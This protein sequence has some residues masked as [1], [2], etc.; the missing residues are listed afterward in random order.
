MNREVWYYT[1]EGELVHHG[2]KGQKWGEKNGPPYPLKSSQ[3]SSSEKAVKARTDAGLGATVALTVMTVAYIAAV[4]KAAKST[5]SKTEAEFRKN[6][7]EYHEKLKKSRSIKSFDDA[8]KLEQK[9][10]PEESMKLTNPDYPLSGTTANCTFCT[11]AM[12]L[13][14]MGYKVKARKSDNL[15]MM[16][17]DLFEAAFGA[18]EHQTSK[19]K[20]IDELSAQGDG[21]YGNL[22]VSSVFGGGHSIFWKNVNGKTRIYD[23]QNGE[24]YTKT[25]DKFDEFMS[26]VADDESVCYQRLDNCKPTEYALALVEKSKR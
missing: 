18:K 24:E 16:T 14:E 5:A 23:G 10:P 21:S 19:T 6:R 9:M 13:R 1:S 2:I 22:S 17:D 25:S 15:G 20:M 8:P 7:K 26:L 12:T 11:T 4:A 3:K